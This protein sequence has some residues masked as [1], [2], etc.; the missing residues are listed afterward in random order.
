MCVKDQETNSLWPH[1][2]PVA[3]SGELD[4]QILDEWGQQWHTTWGTWRSWHPTTMVMDEIKND[5]LHRDMRHGH[6]REEYFERRGIGWLE[7]QYF[8]GSMATPPDERLPE[9]QAVLGINEPEGVRAYPY[10]EVKHNGN[11]VNEALGSLPIVVWS[12]PA[13]NGFSTTAYERRVDGRVLEFELRGGEFVDRQTGSIWHFEGHATSGPLR[14]KQMRQLRCY[15]MRWH[16]WSAHHPR[17]E[18]Y[19]TPLRLSEESRWGIREG[20]FGPILDA[21]RGPLRQ[22][23]EIEEEIVH[24]GLRLGAERGIQIRL[25]GHRLL[26][27][28][29]NGVE[30]A[31]DLEVYPHDWEVKPHCLAHGRFVLKDEPDKQWTGWDQVTRLPDNQI[32]WSPLLR[33]ERFVQAFRAACEA[34]DP[35]AAQREPAMREI[36]QALKANGRPVQD[37]HWYALIV[38]RCA[39]VPRAD[40]V[41]QFFLDV[42]RMLLYRFEA[43]EHALAFAQQVGHAFAVDRYVFRSTPIDMYMMPK[44]EMGQKPD[45]RVTWSAAV[46]DEVFRKECQEAIGGSPWK[47]RDIR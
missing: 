42:D 45:E 37:N 12:D 33:D 25:D 44:F 4:G 16:S 2:E 40:F 10:R 17:T 30:H 34:A 3:F 21:F 8:R 46:A 13:P 38:P 23:V 9:H 7:H 5:P 20:A 1:C 19:R 39:L 27:Y 11:V 18:L 24:Y 29:A 15:F 28:Q 22:T 43:P 36:L 26:L 35:G 6:G 41:L 47:S 32:E 14:G 31:K